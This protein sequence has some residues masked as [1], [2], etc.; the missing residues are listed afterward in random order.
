MFLWVRWREWHTTPMCLQRLKLERDVLGALYFTNPETGM[1]VI[2]LDPKQFGYTELP[3]EQDFKDSH[4]ATSIAMS[5]DKSLVDLHKRKQEREQRRQISK[6][7]ENRAQ[8]F[9]ES[10]KEF[11]IKVPEI[12]QPHVPKRQSS[13]ESGLPSRQHSLTQAD[14]LSSTNSLFVADE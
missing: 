13:G 14:E 9:L 5:G 1:T 4:V 11:N 3:E 6:D 8:S 10:L 7:V 12:Q 2:D